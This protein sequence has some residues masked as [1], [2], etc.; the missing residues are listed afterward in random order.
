MILILSRSKSQ[1]R[2]I[3]PRLLA[4]P[5]VRHSDEAHCCSGLTTAS[6]GGEANSTLHFLAYMLKLFML[7]IL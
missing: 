4:Q 3:I 6:I 2:Q 7:S 5:T 1:A